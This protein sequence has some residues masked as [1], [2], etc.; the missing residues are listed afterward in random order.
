MATAYSTGTSPL[1][2]VVGASYQDGEGPQANQLLNPVVNINADNNTITENYA[3]FGE[4][5]YDLFDGKFVPLVGLRTYHDKRT[6][7]DSTSSLPSTE[8]VTTW[9]VNF[10][11][12]STKDSAP[13]P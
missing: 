3:V 5:S 10:S 8:D 1:H 9:R 13:T 6:F 7:E 4:I 12:C 11:T 2:W